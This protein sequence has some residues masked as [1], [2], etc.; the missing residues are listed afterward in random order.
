MFFSSSSL[1]F[2]TCPPSTEATI[3]VLVVETAFAARLTPLQSSHISFAAASGEK[4]SPLMRILKDEPGV[5][6]VGAA[7][8]GDT[9]FTWGN[10]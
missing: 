5:K 4:L 7:S 3:C 9:T 1:L 6:S 8:V 10:T 2:R